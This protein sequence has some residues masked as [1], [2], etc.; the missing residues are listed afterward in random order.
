[1]NMFN[2]GNNCIIFKATDKDGSSMSINTNRR[3]EV[4]DE[5]AIIESVEKVLNDMQK[6]MKQHRGWEGLHEDEIIGF[7]CECIDEG[8]F[9]MDCAIDFARAIEAKLKERNT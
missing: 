4:S 9:T 1:M 5:V 2:I 3:I 7:A 6:V 8:K